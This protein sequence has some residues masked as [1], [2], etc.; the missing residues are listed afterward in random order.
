MRSSIPPEIA[1]WATLCAGSEKAETIRMKQQE[2]EWRARIAI[3]VL[4]S[5]EEAVGDAPEPSTALDVP[6]S[7][8]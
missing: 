5:M 6:N 3:A 1:F 7:R 2:K 8:L 4:Y